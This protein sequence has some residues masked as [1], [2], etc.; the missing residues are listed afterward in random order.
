[1][2]AN[3]LTEEA[4]FLHMPG[5]LLFQAISCFAEAQQKAANKTALRSEQAQFDKVQVLYCTVVQ[6][7][8]QL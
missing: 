2:L 7:G 8:T 5:E 6:Y 1:M 4:M 3:I